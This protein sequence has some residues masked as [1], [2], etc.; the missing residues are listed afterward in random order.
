MPKVDIAGLPVDTVCMYPD[1]FW[2]ECV[3]RSRKRLGNAIGLTQYGV[4]VTTLK[5]GTWSS[6][7]HFH[8]NEDEF[9]YVLEGEIVL[10][11][12]AGETI[13]KPGNAAG[14]KAGKR[15]G[16]ALINRTDRDAV[17]FEVGTRAKSEH[18]TYSDIDMQ[19][20]RDDSG[21]MVYSRKTSGAPYPKRSG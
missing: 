6:Q 7:R 21:A 9:I 1:P 19:V 14:F 5:P 16:H 13:L 11:E 4:N 18:T 20:K 17:Y 15:N 3:G 12:D 8:A 2:K 10:V